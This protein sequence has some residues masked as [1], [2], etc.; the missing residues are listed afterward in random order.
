MFRIMEGRIL[1]SSTDKFDGGEVFSDGRRFYYS[2]EAFEK[3]SDLSKSQYL[4]EDD[5]GRNL[6]LKYFIKNVGTISAQP[7]KQHLENLRSRTFEIPQNAIN[8]L[9]NLFRGVNRKNFEICKTGNLADLL[10]DKYNDGMNDRTIWERKRT[11][12][13]SLRAKASH[14]KNVGNT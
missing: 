13:A 6:R 1:Q 7:I 10:Y 8:M 2:L 3:K 4:A 14:Y 11:E 12:I 9:D 5:G